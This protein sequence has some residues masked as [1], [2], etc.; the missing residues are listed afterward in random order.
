MPRSRYAALLILLSLLAVIAAPGAASPTAV[1]YYVSSSMGND[2]NNG[3]SAANAFATIAKVNALNLQPG[4]R[5][6]LKCGDVW[7]AEQLILSKSG[8]ALAPIVFSSYPEGCANKPS[9]SGSRSIGGWVQDSGSVYRA[10][11][12]AADFPLGINQLFRNGQ[13]L[14]L[15]RWPNLNDPNGGYAFVEAHTAGGN[16]ITDNELPAGRLDRRDRAS[17][18]H[19]LVDDRSAGDGHQRPCVDTQSGL[20]VFD[21]RL[22]QLCGLGVFHQQSSC[23]ARSRRRVVLRCSAAPRLSLLHERRTEQHRRLGHSRRRRHPAARRPDVE[24]R[25]GHRLRDRRQSGDQELVQSRHRHAGRHERRHLS[26]PHRAQRD[27]QRRGQCRGESEQLAGTTVEWPQRSARRRSSDVHQ[28]RHRWGE[29]L[30][31]HR[32]L[33][34]LHV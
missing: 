24:Q 21:L 30:R 27:D 17:E 1:T 9:L 10:D 3:L 28:Q 23:H 29:R 5:V 7:H 19:P 13:R 12:S 4:D 22:G 26:S 34:R 15:G 16:Q 20:L 6:L 32:L 2:N 25:R 18:E 11:L 8:T 14:T 31:H 33:R